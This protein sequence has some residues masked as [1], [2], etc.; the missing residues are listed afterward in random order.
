[1]QLQLLKSKL[2]LAQV[3][4]ADLNCEGSLTIALDLMEQAYLAPYE[5]VLCTNMANGE[6]FET[7][8]IPGPRGSSA[9]V[10]NGNAAYNGQPGDR[11]TIMSFA[12]VDSAEA[13]NWQPRVIVLGENNAVVNAR[14]I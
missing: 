7:Y 10:L 11:L 5:R 6:R 9:I 12:F 13:K 14:G 4:A 8:A 1:M 2:H 3:T